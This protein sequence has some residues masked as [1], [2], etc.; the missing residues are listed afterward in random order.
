MSDEPTG[1]ID[2]METLVIGADDMLVIRV[3][4]HITNTELDRLVGR[5]R[6]GNPTFYGRIVVVSHEFQLA[7]VTGGKL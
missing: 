5:L 2:Q 3:P 6:D 7:K 1:P 4:A